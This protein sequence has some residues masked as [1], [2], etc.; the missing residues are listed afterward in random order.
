MMFASVIVSTAITKI[1]IRTHST[2]R[3]MYIP[4]IL[5]LT[6]NAAILGTTDMYP[7]SGADAPSYT[8]GA[9]VWKGKRESLNP[10]ATSNNTDEPKIATIRPVSFTRVA[11]T[12][13]TL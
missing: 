3:S 6:T 11:K 12:S 2:P 7:A 8:S 10:N 1:T 5:I 9:Q 4:K 13:A